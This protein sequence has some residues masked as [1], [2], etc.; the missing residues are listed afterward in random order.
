MAELKLLPDIETGKPIGDWAVRGGVAVFFVVF[1]MEKI[2]IGR[3]IALGEAVCADRGRG[4]VPVFYWR[5]G[6]A[7]GLLVL[8]PK[9][10]LVGLAMLACSM[11]GAVVI[12]AFVVG[13]PGSSIFPG[14]FLVA[15]M[16]IGLVQWG[17]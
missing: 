12:L 10:A 15:P 17:R 16:G 1:G 9:T 4:V 13:E 7:G 11:A 8:I 14:M 5:G 2:L 3:G 6:G